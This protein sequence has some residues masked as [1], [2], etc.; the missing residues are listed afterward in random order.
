VKGLNCCQNGRGK[1]EANYAE[2]RIGKSITDTNLYSAN[3]PEGRGEGD[4]VAHPGTNRNKRTKKDLEQTTGGGGENSRGKSRSTYRKR[5]GD[6]RYVLARVDP[7][8][9]RGLVHV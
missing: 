7:A 5:N 8:D 3:R 1:H 9:P 4:R 6:T 2:K